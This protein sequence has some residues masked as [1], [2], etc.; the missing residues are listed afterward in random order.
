MRYDPFKYHRRSIRLKGYDYGQPG[1]YFITL[2]LQDN[3]CLLGQ[4]VDVEMIAN[5]AGE[6]IY[7]EWLALPDRFETVALDAFVVMPN[8][9]HGIICP[10][11]CACPRSHP[12]PRW[13]TQ[14]THKGCPNR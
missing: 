11:S 1:A 3:S 8:H 7:H 10:R 5:A 6:M 9:L 12:R 14:G 2:C 4:A 13:R